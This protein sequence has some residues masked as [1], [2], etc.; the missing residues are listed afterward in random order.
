[1]AKK[2]VLLR[3]QEEDWGCRA[4]C[5]CQQHWKME[6]GGLQGTLH[7]IQGGNNHG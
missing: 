1:M 7:V 3:K 5:G 2:A 4:L 6:S